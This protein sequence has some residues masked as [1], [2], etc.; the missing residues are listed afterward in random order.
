MFATSFET[1]HYFIVHAFH[2]PK[3]AVNIING[4]MHQE[5]VC[6]AFLG[7]CPQR[8]DFFWQKKREGK[9][10]TVSAGV[11][12]EVQKRRRSGRTEPVDNGLMSI[13]EIEYSKFQTLFRLVSFY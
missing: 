13:V 1:T 3:T 4:K 5:I 12:E 8:N 7:M 9:G 2:L 10:K 11:K 6:R